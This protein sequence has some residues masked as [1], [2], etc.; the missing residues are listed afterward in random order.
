MEGFCVTEMQGACNK[1]VDNNLTNT[2]LHPKY[3]CLAYMYRQPLLIFDF[4]SRLQHRLCE[5]LKVLNRAQEVNRGGQ[6][7]L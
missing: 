7:V 1:S 3:A 4:C 5:L 6:R 2:Y